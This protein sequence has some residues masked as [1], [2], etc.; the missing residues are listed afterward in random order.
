MVQLQS[1][2]VALYRILYWRGQLH[3][4]VD[5][6]STLRLDSGG[7]GGSI[8]GSF[9]IPNG[10]GRDAIF[11]RTRSDVRRFETLAFFSDV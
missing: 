11:V 3:P 8:G 6:V 1:N 9:F 4:Q 2:V 5:E 7:F 10:F